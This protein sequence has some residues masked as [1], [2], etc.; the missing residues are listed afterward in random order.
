MNLVHMFDELEASH[1][2]IRINQFWLWDPILPGWWEKESHFFRIFLTLSGGLYLGLNV[3]KSDMLGIH[4]GCWTSEVAFSILL[5]LSTEA[6]SGVYDYLSWDWGNRLF[7]WL[8]CFCEC[9]S[10]S[11]HPPRDSAHFL[12][13]L[14]GSWIWCLFL[15]A[16]QDSLLQASPSPLSTLTL[17]ASALKKIGSLLFLPCHKMSW[18]QKPWTCYQ[19]ESGWGTWGWSIGRKVHR[20]K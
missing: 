4:S 6:G 8:R 18:P 7:A 11:L 20:G 10:H 15:L 2:I 5:S 12:K 19:F 3:L 17:F 9:I 13:A 16:S 1:F 14:P